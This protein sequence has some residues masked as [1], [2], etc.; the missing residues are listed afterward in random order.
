MTPHGMPP[1]KYA[2]TVRAIARRTVTASMHREYTGRQAAGPL[3][4]AGAANRRA[5]QKHRRGPADR[6]RVGRNERGPRQGAEVVHRARGQRGA[7]LVERRRRRPTARPRP[8][9]RG[10]A[11]RSGSPASSPHTATG[12]PAAS[13]PATTPAIARRTAGWSA[14]WKRARIALPRSAAMRY[15]VRSFVPMLKNATRRASS[16]ARRVAAGTSTMIP[17][18]I[19]SAHGWPA[20]RPRPGPRRGARRAGRR[21]RAWR[22]SGP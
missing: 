9:R 3:I 22:P 12:M 21:P 10:R 5:R 14:S 6:G 1:M 15:W 8:G 20:A 16:G 18:T 4:P 13:A 19:V 7:D 2:A 11:R 17:V